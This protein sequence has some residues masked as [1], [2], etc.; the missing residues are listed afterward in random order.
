M[1]N[2]LC[3]ILKLDLAIY[4]TVDTFCGSSFTIHWSKLEFLYLS[5]TSKTDCLRKSIIH[6]RKFTVVKYIKLN[7]CNFSSSGFCGDYTLF[8]FLWQL[9]YCLQFSALSFQKNYPDRKRQ[10]KSIRFL[11]VLSQISWT[12]FKTIIIDTN[13]QD[14]FAFTNYWSVRVWRILD[15][16]PNNIS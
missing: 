16:W 5:E 8:S 11:E 9:F 7:L 2:F 3:N 6:Q 1:G 14:R 13:Q 4:G 15:A 12:T 10:N